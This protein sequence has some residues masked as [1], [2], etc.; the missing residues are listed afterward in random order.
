MIEVSKFCGFLEDENISFYTGV[1]DSQLKPF[2][3]FIT[4]KWGT[5]GNHI[6]AVNEGNAVALAAGHFLATGKVGLVYM[7]NSGLGNAVNP[8]T[9][10][11]DPEVYG[12]PVIYM[13]GWRG[14]P[15]VKDEPQHIKQ[16]QITEQL[17]N[18][19]GIQYVPVSQQTSES[20]LYELYK[21]KLKPLL[22]EGR[23]V[24]F[25]I[26][27]GALVNST[28]FCYSNQNTLTREHAI[29]IMLDQ[30]PVQ[31]I[32]V[33]TTGKA[34]RELFEY[35]ENTQA[36]HQRDFLTV[37]SMGHASMIALSIA[38][39][40]NV[41][42]WCFD[43]DGAM[44]MHM[45]ALA[46]I[47]NRKPRHFIHVLLNNESHETVGGMPTISTNMYWITIS[48]TLGYA[49]S[50]Q[51]HTEKEL[52][53]VLGQVQQQNGPVFIEVLVAIGSRSDLMRPNIKPIENKQNIMKYLNTV[54]ENRNGI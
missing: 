15:G 42:V 22:S 23:S 51:V 9:S 53:Q 43:G 38:E 6:I 48:K 25:L 46:L 1:P 36:D 50:Y 12:I 45:G 20:E 52:K 40:V 13:I 4:A 33:S 41:P 54:V 31:S 26:E 21:K 17:L 10:L 16:G 47:G 49:A 34:S 8:I 27:K 18:I 14:Q 30:Q 28:S 19:L 3:D 32:N 2:C 35:R 24:A 5:D 39:N 37:G 7:Q 11:T 29:Q 44:L